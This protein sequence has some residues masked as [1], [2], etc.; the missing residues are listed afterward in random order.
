M[1]K[2]DFYYK[3]HKLW[4]NVYAPV[5]NTFNK[6]NVMHS[7]KF[8]IGEWVEFDE[9]LLY[10]AFDTFQWH[11]EN[12]IKLE[13]LILETPKGENYADFYNQIKSDKEI[14]E[15]YD[16]WIDYKER[17]YDYE[18]IS[19]YDHDVEVAFTEEATQALIK[20]IKIRSSVWI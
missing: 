4:R 12:D 17:I 2:S 11:V 9:K 5:K 13:N 15:L 6:T 1:K 20:L 19:D 14:K 3:A 8:K 7:S 16:W 18:T 10:C